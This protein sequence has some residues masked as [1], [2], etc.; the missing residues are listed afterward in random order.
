MPDTQAPTA[1]SSLIT[2]T[3]S[4]GQINLSWSGSTDNVGVTN[5]LIE[6]CQGAGCTTFAQVGTSTGLTFISTGLT[7]GTSYSFRV[8]ATDAA[9][10]LSAYTPV[11]TATT[12]GAPLLS[13]VQSNFSAPQSTQTTVTVPYTL[14]QS[15]GNLNVVVVGWNSSSNQV[16]S[17]TDT[18][19]NL[20]VLAVGPTVFSGF[21]TQSIYYAA[22]I[23]PAS[24]GNVVT[25]VF[26]AAVPYVDIRIAEY[27]GIT[28]VNPIDAVAAAQ[29]NGTLGN[30]GAVTTTNPTDLIVGAN[31]VA[32]TTTGPGTSFTSR[33]LS[34][35]DADILEDRVVATAGSYNATAPMSSGSWIMQ[36][37]AF[38][39]G[40]FVPDTQ[41]PSAVTGWSHR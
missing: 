11:S 27:A 34:V 21:A 33:V 28:S 40:T 25:V 12:Q 35:P 13:F 32:S 14:A 29:G 20:Y 31:I 30:S 26:N 17:V 18:R 22:N 10:N 9:G 1:P 4:S 24:A 38:K 16:Q 19:G 41:A 7:A 39:G 37:V 36:M 3:I 15:L 6:L 8:R 5:Y 23:L 2:T